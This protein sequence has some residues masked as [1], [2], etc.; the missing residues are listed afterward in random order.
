MKTLSLVLA[1][2]SGVTL[3]VSSAGAATTR[4]ASNCS[5]AAV[6]AAIDA[7]APGDTVVVPNGSCTRTSGVV[8]NGKGVQLRGQSANGVI[9]THNGG[10]I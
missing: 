10:A 9:I 4:T 5:S 3:A 8:I 6:Q 1:L 7:A 2:L